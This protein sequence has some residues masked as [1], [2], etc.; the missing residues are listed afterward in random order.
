MASKF[1]HKYLFR[2]EIDG[3]E[4]AVFE[5]CSDLAGEVEDVVFSPAGSLRDHSEPG[6]VKFDDITL[7][8]GKTNSL[9]LYNLWEETVKADAGMDDDTIEVGGGTGSDDTEMHFDIV[10]LNRSGSEKAR[11][12]VVTD[13]VKRYVHGSWDS[14]ANEVVVQSITFKTQQWKPVSK[15][16]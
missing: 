14:K 2:I 16:A 1:S 15:S 6:K 3:V 10:E 4:R 13:Y 5:T 9:E 12:R 11:N 7:T 8:A